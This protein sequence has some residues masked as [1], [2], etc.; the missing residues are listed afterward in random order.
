MRRI[1]IIAL[2]FAMCLG[3]AACDE[4]GEVQQGKCTAFDDATKTMTV[5]L[6]VLNP[7]AAPTYTGESVMVKLP[8]D[9]K[10]CGPAP[11]VGDIVRYYYKDK[12]QALRFMNVTR[13]NIYKK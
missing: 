6:E 13:T 9:P 7:G 10:E 1:Q 12:G 8:M 3:L 11:Q 5:T 2:I 4:Y